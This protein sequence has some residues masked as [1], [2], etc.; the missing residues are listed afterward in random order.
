MTTRAR[1]GIAL[2]QIIAGAW[3]LAD[4]AKRMFTDAHTGGQYILAVLVAALMVTSIVAGV[5]LWR[6][7]EQ[8]RALS[9]A[10]QA[11]QVPVLASKWFVYSVTLGLACL[12]GI[13]GWG[14]SIWV[15]L[16]PHVTIGFAPLTYVPQI[17]INLVPL[18]LWRLLRRSRV[19]GRPATEAVV[20]A[21]A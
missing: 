11:L 14:P 19:P 6:D 7:T 3:G 13:R 10:V 21:A 20:R 2:Y 5:L 15:G 8:G 9:R 4:P 1:R 18:V 12:V 17:S 16:G